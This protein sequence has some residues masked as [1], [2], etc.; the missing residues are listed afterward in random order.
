MINRVITLNFLR[1]EIL[2]WFIMLG[3][4]M[5]TYLLGFLLRSDFLIIFSAIGMFASTI[6]LIINRYYY[7]FLKRFKK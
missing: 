1:S 4:S 2:Y 6:L 7:D 3:A 5:L